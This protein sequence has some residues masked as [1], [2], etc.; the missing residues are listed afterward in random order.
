M[1]VGKARSLSPWLVATLVVSLSALCVPAGAAAPRGESDKSEETDAETPPGVVERV[2]V[3]ATRLPD[4]PQ[5]SERVP[6]HVTVIDRERIARSGA[7]TL[8]DLLALEAG[9]VV[10]DQVGNFIEKTFDLRGFTGG[11]GTRVFLDGAPLNEP[12]NNALLLDLVPLSS[13]ERIEIIR[14]SSAALGGGGSEAGVIHLRTRQGE[15]GLGGGLTLSAGS[16]DTRML[17]GRVQGREGRF[18]FFLA[19]HDEETDGFR[20]NAGGDRTQWSATGGVDLGGDRR[21]ELSLVRSES[22]LGN[23]GALTAGELADDPGGAPYNEADFSDQTLDQIALNYRGS[24]SETFSVAANVMH[25]NRESR[26]L[27]TGRSAE[28]L[29]GFYSELDTRVSGAT[30][31]LSHTTRGAR[32]EN[33]LTLGVE[34][35]DGETEA[36]GVSTPDTDPGTVDT[37]NP[38]SMNTADRRTAALFVQDSWQPVAEVQVGLGLRFD[39][40]RVGYDETIPVPTPTVTKDF[41]ELSLRA[42]VTWSP[43]RRHAFYASYGE[44]FLPP[45]AEQLFAFP[46]FG[47]NPELEPEDSATY[48][49]GATGRYGRETEIRLA[50]LRVDTDNEIVF[51]TSTFQNVNAGATRREGIEASVRLRPLRALALFANVT[52]IDARFQGGPNDGNEVPLSPRGRLAVGADWD[53]P[54][55][56]A[57]RADLLHVGEQVLDGDDANEIDRLAPYTVAN[58]RLTWHAARNRA[59]REGAVRGLRFFAEARNVLDETYATRGIFSGFLVDS[60]F[61]PAPGRN[62]LFGAG[63]DF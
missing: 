11:A 13:L 44:G 4:A 40:D 23:P 31:Q 56:L 61:T 16:F 59:A 22:D 26:L 36:L 9:A 17:D 49:L 8:Q 57:L 54:A 18:S 39:D 6:A 38:A 1:V 45:T 29:G 10:Y 12:R 55:G 28:F 53:L 42:G 51:D 34:Y 58:V 5:P 33:R 52:L 32:R 47:S 60:F 35:L 37:S 50:I 20:T 19:G 7:R 63:W 21:L 24:L 46:T 41:E 15:A 30:V 14:G 2:E 48:E 62:Y 25:R 27:T 3:S 43:L